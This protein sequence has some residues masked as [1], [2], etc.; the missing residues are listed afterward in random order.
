MAESYRDVSQ[1]RYGNGR[2]EMQN[3]DVMELR[4][5]LIKLTLKNL[6]VELAHLPGGARKALVI[7]A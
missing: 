6:E 4:T 5:A 2:V 3:G 1:M 7:N